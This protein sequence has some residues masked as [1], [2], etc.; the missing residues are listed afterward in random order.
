MILEKMLLPKNTRHTT[1]FLFIISASSLVRHG[2]CAEKRL[3]MNSVFSED[4]TILSLASDLCVGFP[5]MLE[6]R[7]MVQLCRYVER[8]KKRERE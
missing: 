8:E 4:K 2:T 1:F 7:S 3:L 5:C 6:D